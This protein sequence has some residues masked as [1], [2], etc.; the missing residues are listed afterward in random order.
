MI[1]SKILQKR[2]LQNMSNTIKNVLDHTGT[3][4]M[5]HVAKT[6]PQF[7]PITPRWL[8]KVLSWKALEA[9]VFRLNKVKEGSSILHGLTSEEENS[10]ELEALFSKYNSGILNAYANVDSEAREYVLDDISAVLPIPVK[11]IDVHSQP[12]DQIQEQMRIVMESLEEQQ[13]S[14]L[15]NDSD[16]G[17][18]NN[19][20]DKQKISSVTGSPTPDDMDELLSKVWKRPSFF[21]AHP[22][23]I[24]A[25]G[26][27]CTRRGVPPV[28]IQYEGSPFLSWRGIPIFP[29]D[30][31]LVD[32]Q[33]N[34]MGKGGKTNIL[35]M[36]TGE[37]NQGVIGLHQAN[38][39]GEQ[40]RGL[41]VRFMGINNHGIASYLLSIY[42][43]AAVLADDAIAVLENVEV[44]NYYDYS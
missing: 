36:R 43:S 12:Y 31:L 13:E 4:Q 22:R 18:L 40:S 19:I 38:L 44:G 10:S 33:K 27:E 32:G 28:T 2:R 34:P 24:A 35:L 21:L 30:K 20:A 6:P 3:Y 39:Q 42:C 15:I 8:T 11:I 17:L 29:S 14:H 25:F 1:H 7:E 16:Y 37:E 41:S 23:A 9:G 26:R 5:S